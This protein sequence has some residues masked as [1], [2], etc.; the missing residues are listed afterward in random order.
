MTTPYASD[1][2]ESRKALFVVLH[3]WHSSPARLRDIKSTIEQSVAG[4]KVVLTPPLPYQALFSF[5]RAAAIVRDIIELIDAQVAEHGFDDIVLVGH[6]FGAVVARRVFLV[7]HGTPNDFQNEEE[8]LNIPA[9][10]W[11]KS[12]RRIVMIATFNRGWQISERLGWLYGLYFNVIGLLGHILSIGRAVPTVFDIRLGAPFIVQ[13]RLHWLAHRRE[14]RRTGEDAND[15][16]VIQLMGTRDNLI[17]PFDQVDIAVDGTFTAD[18]GRDTRRQRYF[19]LEMPHTAHSDAIVFTRKQSN[20]PGWCTIRRDLFIDALTKSAG[21]LHDIAVDP[22]LLVDQVPTQDLTAES[23][24]FVIH[25]IRDDGFWTHRI[26][27]RI[28]QTDDALKLFRGW[29]PS[30]GYF[31]MMPFLLPWIRRQKVEWFMDQYVSAKAQYPR[32][33]NFHYVGHSNGTFLAA[34]ALANYPALKLGRV[35]FAG[36]VVRRDY[37]WKEVVAR[38]AVARFLNVRASRDWV[39]AL[40]PKSVEYLKDIDLGGAGFDGFDQ[41]NSTPDIRELSAFVKGGHGAGV[42]EQYW[43]MIANFI[44]AGTIPAEDR[45]E[46]LVQRRPGWLIVL[47]KLR[48]GIP[49]IVALA[50][51]LGIAILQPVIAHFETSN[52][53]SASN[54]IGSVVAFTLYAW[55]VKFFITRF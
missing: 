22:A 52:D 15:P 40:L 27:E 10:A 8:L 35:Y 30:Y 31:A 41:A 17:S 42:S 51:I 11:A 21:E 19:F 37:D 33:T 25:G 54:A 44:V 20:D 2:Y 18:A 6:S 45:Q 34:G 38:G 50:I 16:I 23:V 3:G 7:A 12:V 39:V 49:V 26:A 43:Q 9:K 47:S 1:L 48:L 29:T 4:E 55:L 28:R 13:T 36:S 24:V 32:A 46:G 53:L 5:K 14:L